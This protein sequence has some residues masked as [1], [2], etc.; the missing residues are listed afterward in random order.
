MY[1][2]PEKRDAAYFGYLSYGQ[3]RRIVN[4]LHEV[5]FYFPRAKRLAAKYGV[6]VHII[7]R[8]RHHYCLDPRTRT[9]AHWDAQFNY[10]PRS[11]NRSVTM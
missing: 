4:G 9:H 7:E 8:I 6:S 11:W 2:E 3:R 1:W 10:P 5:F